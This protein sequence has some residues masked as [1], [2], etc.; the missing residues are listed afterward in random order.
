MQLLTNS[1]VAL[2][3]QYSNRQRSYSTFFAIACFFF[4]LISTLPHRYEQVYL[5][6]G[7]VAVFTRGQPAR[8]DDGL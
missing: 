6:V 2:S 4:D 5:G 8:A 3:N 7:V 1:D